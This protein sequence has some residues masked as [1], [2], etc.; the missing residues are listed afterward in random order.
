[1]IPGVSRSGATIIGSLCLGV[2]RK[3]ATEFSFF[4]AIPTMLG[5]SL[6]DLYMNWDLLTFSALEMIA[7][8]FVCAFVSGL[9]VVRTLV[10]FVSNHGF[11]PFAWYRMA[12]GSV[13]LFLFLQ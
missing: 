13:M 9:V 3:T 8:G 12:L 11:A 1:M 10:S 4:L 2:D 6:F 5:A 7:L